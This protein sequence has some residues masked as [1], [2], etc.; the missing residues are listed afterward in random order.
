MNGRQVQSD[1]ADTGHCVAKVGHCQL[2]HIVVVWPPKIL[3]Q[4]AKC[5]YEKR[6][7][8]EA[9]L[10]DSLMIIEQL[11]AAYTLVDS[12][13]AYDECIGRYHPTK[14]G[15]VRLKFAHHPPN[16]QT[17]PETGRPIPLHRTDHPPHKSE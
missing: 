7:V 5:G 1:L 6:G 11:Q 2:P 3:V 8:Y 14:Q 9:K 12:N 16:L 4:L 13:E 10:R 17:A 15:G